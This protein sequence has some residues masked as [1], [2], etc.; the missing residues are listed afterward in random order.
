M[1]DL[2]KKPD[3]SKKIYSAIYAKAEQLYKQAKA[4]GKSESDSKSVVI[5][6]L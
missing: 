6:N 1:K 3:P 2:F 4:E 5:K